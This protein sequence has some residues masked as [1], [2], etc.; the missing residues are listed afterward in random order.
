[1]KKSLFMLLALI[2]IIALIPLIINNVKAE[3]MDKSS[4]LYYYEKEG[5]FYFD[6]FIEKGG[7][8]SDGQVVEFLSKKIGKNI[9]IGNIASNIFACSTFQVKS[10]NGYLTGR[11]FDFT[12]C[13]AAILKAIPQNGYKSISTIDIDFIG[14]IYNLVPEELKP[15]VLYYAPLDGMNE[16][17]LV[18][19][20]NMIEDSDSIEQSSNKNDITTT[21]AI[22]LL[23]D[24]ASNT[25]EAIELLKK[26]NLHAS[27]NMM[28]HFFIS[29]ASGKSV[30]VEYINNEMSIVETK[31]LTNYYLTEGKKYG[32]GTQESHE[33]YNIL[34]T[35]ILQTKN[36]KIDE[37]MNL[38]SEVSKKNFTTFATTEWSIVFDQFN[39]TYNLCHRENYSKT[40]TYDLR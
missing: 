28:V 1:M 30:A 15:Y 4:D 34:N 7:A 19:A 36:Y 27:K 6:E 29:D 8:K 22:R 25:D 37:A 16:K 21:T 38:L 24:K 40:H 9:D 31:I 26:N 39:L 33:R 32:I 20:V 17:G 12:R 11:N 13:K 10:E 2:G 3:F 14:S 18:V 5:D 35:N 23:L